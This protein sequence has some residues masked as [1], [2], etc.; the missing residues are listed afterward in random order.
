MNSTTYTSTKSEATKNQDNSFEN[1]CET[2][3]KKEYKNVVREFK[4]KHPHSADKI[5]EFVQ[6]GK[7]YIKNHGGDDVSR[8]DMTMDEYKAF[9]SDLINKVPF[10]SSQLNDTQMWSVTEEG[11]DQMK[12][13]P[14]YE[15]W[16]LGYMVIDRSVHFPFQTSNIH[17]EKFGAS[18]E[19]HIGHSF[20]KDVGNAAKADKKEDSW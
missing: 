4:K 12:N 7:D 17:T 1:V 6:K 16:V 14:E 20:P 2:K 13:D 18:I 10:D 8:S 3:A 19:E 9:I 11:W 15:A 5:D